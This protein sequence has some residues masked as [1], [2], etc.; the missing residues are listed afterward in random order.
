MQIYNFQLRISHYEMENMSN[1][2]ISNNFLEN[3]KSKHSINNLKKISTYQ[4]FQYLFFHLTH[5]KVSNKYLYS[6]DLFRKNLQ[7]FGENILNTQTI[8]LEKTWTNL[9]WCFVLH[10][11]KVGV[12]SRKEDGCHNF[13]LNQ[14]GI[15]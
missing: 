11:V 1:I 2:S 3:T 15:A 10:A 14:R 13:S 8:I 5:G 9:E 6:F 12:I 7:N 4:Y